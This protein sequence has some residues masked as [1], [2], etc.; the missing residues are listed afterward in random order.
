MR[1]IRAPRACSE[2]IALLPRRHEHVRM[3]GVHV[4]MRGVHVRMRG[5]HVRTA[6]AAHQMVY[7]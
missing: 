4:R 2:A 6:A 3:R 5:V 1:A 7:L